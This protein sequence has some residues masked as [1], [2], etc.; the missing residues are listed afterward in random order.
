M[1]I[2]SKPHLVKPPLSDIFSAQINLK[3]I[4]VS[5]KLKIWTLYLFISFFLAVTLPTAV[6]SNV[7]I[8]AL[9]TSILFI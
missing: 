3:E 7:K 5:L 4:L 9:I 8:Y 2:Y 6:I 1:E